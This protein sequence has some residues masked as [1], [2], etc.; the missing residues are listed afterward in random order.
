LERRKLEGK[1]KV[2]QTLRE[3]GG[4]SAKSGLWKNHN[5]SR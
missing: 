3:R 2:H 4:V 5:E 1:L